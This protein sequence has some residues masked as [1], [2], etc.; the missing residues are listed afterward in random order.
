MR[1]ERETST[2]RRFWNQK[3]RRDEGILRI[4]LPWYV[5]RDQRCLLDLPP[6]RSRSADAKGASDREM[7]GNT[8]NGRPR[9][10]IP[11]A[12]EQTALTHQE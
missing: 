9:S 7:N 3:K 1:A 11:A 4:H 6:A 8:V 10:E 5:R 2:E 12:Q